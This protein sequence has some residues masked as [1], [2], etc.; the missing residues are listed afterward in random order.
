MA[1]PRL[2]NALDRIEAA[3]D[4]IESR[5]VVDAERHARLREAVAESVAGMDRLIA[6]GGE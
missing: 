5:P 3:L 2:S 6:A 1:D 4:R